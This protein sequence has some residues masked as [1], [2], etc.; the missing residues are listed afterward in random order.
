LT[1]HVVRFSG[2]NILVGGTE[3]RPTS[4]DES[5]RVAA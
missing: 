2:C 1:E 3:W 5:A 4:E